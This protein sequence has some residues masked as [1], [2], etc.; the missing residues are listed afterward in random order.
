IV[1]TSDEARE[2]YQGVAGAGRGVDVFHRRELDRRPKVS[3]ASSS[4]VT[5][6]GKNTR[7]W[8]G[9]AAAWTYFTAANWIA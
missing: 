8:Q 6:P 5:K 2:K 3:S 7:A 4:P 1:I 9:L